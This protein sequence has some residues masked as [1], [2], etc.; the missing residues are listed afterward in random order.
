MDLAG[1][2]Q[3]SKC[4][5]DTSLLSALVSPFVKCKVCQAALCK[6]S[7]S[8]FAT[9]ALR[10]TYKMCQMRNWRAEGPL[11]LDSE[12]SIAQQWEECCNNWTSLLIFLPECINHPIAKKTTLHFG[13]ETTGLRISLIC[14]TG[15]SSLS[16]SLDFR[17]FMLLVLVC[18][19]RFKW[20]NGAMLKSGPKKTL[21]KQAFALSWVSLTEVPYISPLRQCQGARENRNSTVTQTGRHNVCALPLP[22]WI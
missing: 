6:D 13:R 8:V 2:L 4:G 12:A 3:R 18:F 9:C 20:K 21:L 17:L 19:R 15:V 22:L 11:G 5:T 14:L 10:L 16:I 1:E 7:C